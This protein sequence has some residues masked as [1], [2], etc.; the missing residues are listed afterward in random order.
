MLR[1][2]A[3]PIIHIPLNSRGFCIFK[4]NSFERWNGLCDFVEYLKDEIP[5]PNGYEIKISPHLSLQPGRAIGDGAA[6]TNVAIANAVS[7]SG[8]AGCVRAPISLIASNFDA[9][10]DS[11]AFVNG[12]SQPRLIECEEATPISHLLI[13]LVSQ[14]LSGVGLVIAVQ[15][16]RSLVAWI[17][18]L[19]KLKI[20]HIRKMTRYY[21]YYYY[22]LFFIFYFF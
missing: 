21:Y 20:Y 13:V 1:G 16:P 15:L 7:Q 4:C 11:C 9:Q 2:K 19:A 17:R 18:Q 6:I 5:K 12:A 14:C 22:F 10:E 3:E 8:W